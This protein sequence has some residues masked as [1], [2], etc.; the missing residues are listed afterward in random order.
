MPGLWAHNRYWQTQA[1][2]PPPDPIVSA[3]GGYVTW[4]PAVILGS[5]LGALQTIWE[6]LRKATR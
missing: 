6:W 2:E 3:N 4:Q 5:G 1:A